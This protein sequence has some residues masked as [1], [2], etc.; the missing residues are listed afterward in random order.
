MASPRCIGASITITQTTT[1]A[2]ARKKQWRPLP[3]L[4]RHRQEQQADLKWIQATTVA[5]AKWPDTRP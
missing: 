2:T 5:V 1:P 4:Q 3:R